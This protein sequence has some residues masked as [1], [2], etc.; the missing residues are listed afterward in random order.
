MRV[1]NRV[2]I[3]SQDQIGCLRYSPWKSVRGLVRESIARSW[4]YS[5]LA[6]DSKLGSL[7]E[8][9]L[10]DRYEGWLEG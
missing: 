5:E 4:F 8:S 9:Q 1:A 3:G 7:W 6:K 10:E 2:A